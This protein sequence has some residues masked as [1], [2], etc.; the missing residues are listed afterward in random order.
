MS[1]H[2]VNTSE[3]RA[4]RHAA[5]L[6]VCPRCKDTGS[7]TRTVS[8]GGGLIG[9]YVETVLCF[10]CGLLGNPVLGTDGLAG[11]IKKARKP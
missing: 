10:D 7:V 5:G 2:V 3:A 11:A 4:A 8:A 1:G 6:T 9:S